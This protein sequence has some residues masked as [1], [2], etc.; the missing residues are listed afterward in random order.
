MADQDDVRIARLE[1]QVAALTSMAIAEAEVLAPTPFAREVAR[2]VAAIPWGSTMT[3]GEVAQ[4]AGSPG[5]AMSVG[6]ALTLAVSA[7]LPIPWWRVVPRTRR[8]TGQFAAERRLLLAAEGVT[9]EG[10]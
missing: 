1:A 3:Y 4:R 6:R 9:L 5:A 10:R 7:G 2:V 8:L